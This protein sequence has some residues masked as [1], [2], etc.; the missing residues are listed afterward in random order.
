MKVSIVTTG[1]EIMAG[2]VID[3]NAHWMA[4]QCWNAGA[5]VVWRVA[6]ADDL[7]EIG[8]ACKEAIRR[9]DVVLVSGGLGPTADDITLKAAAKAFGK[10]LEFNPNVFKDIENFF[11]RV[12]RPMSES[13]RKQ[14]FL[15]K[16]AQPLPN[17]LGTAPGSQVQLGKATFFFMPGVPRELHI[18]CEDFVFPWIKEKMSGK[19]F[20]QEKIFHCFGVPE[21][22]LDTFLK[23]VKLGK[24]RL[25]F[26]YH[27]PETA[28][29]LACWDKNQKVVE[30]ELSKAAKNVYTKVGEYIY[31]EGDITLSKVIG[32]LLKKRKETLSVA[33]SC[34]GGMVADTITNVSGASAYFERGVVVYS[35][36]SKQDLL[37]VK[38]GTLKKFGA[39]SQEVAKEMAEGIRKMSKTTYGI[40]VT[41][42][43]G[44]TG[45][46]KERPI[47]TV[48]IALAT[49]KTTEV[50]H[51]CFERDRVEFKQL[52]SAIALDWLRK[53]LL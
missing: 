34:T 52:V 12:G 40:A 15:I 42:I 46:T 29:K 23:G 30:Q 26:R 37:G 17:K 38:E 41:G 7:K 19:I 44:P 11:K 35:N 32:E 45:G 53:T 36:P 24:A 48:Y 13:N 2:N 21:A 51:F 49:P 25:S 39:V 10:K 1:D 8:D 47:G 6:V 4:T 5:K 28:L 3:N 18:L 31:G 43:A 14:A 9:A 22:S 20:F 27:F 16:E 50:K 33:E